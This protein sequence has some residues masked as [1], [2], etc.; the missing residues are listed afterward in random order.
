[1]IA[2]DKIHMIK[3]K[4][5]QR[6]I[7]VRIVVAHHNIRRTVIGHAIIRIAEAP[8]NETP[9]QS[10]QESVQKAMTFRL[11]FTYLHSVAGTFHEYEL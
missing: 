10:D 6:G 11:P 2:G 9:D 5:E 1:M 4:A 8:L 7:Q 3:G